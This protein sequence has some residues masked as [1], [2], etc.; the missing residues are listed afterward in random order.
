MD[1]IGTEGCARGHIDRP[2]PS[3]ATRAC[4]SGADVGTE[5]CRLRPCAR[6]GPPCTRASVVLCSCV[7]D[8][9]AVSLRLGF[10]CSLLW[11]PVN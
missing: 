4:G 1:D 6:A 10:S 7:R 11:A 3:L 5:G 2:V 9:R 8:Q